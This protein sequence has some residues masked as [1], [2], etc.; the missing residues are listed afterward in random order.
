MTVTDKEATASI[1]SV[2]HNFCGRII[3]DPH[4]NYSMG[5]LKRKH[6]EKAKFKLVWK[7]GTDGTTTEQYDVIFIISNSALKMEK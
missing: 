3:K 6:G 1:T 7:G 4:V 2:L 5:N